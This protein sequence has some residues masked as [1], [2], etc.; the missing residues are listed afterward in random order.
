VTT[1]MIPVPS[2]FSSS[3]C[4]PHEMNSTSGSFIAL[5]CYTKTHPKGRLPVA[6]GGGFEARQSNGR[7]NVL[8]ITGKSLTWITN[9]HLQDG[10]IR[11]SSLANGE[12]RNPTLIQFQTGGCEMAKMAGIIR[13]LKK[14]EH[15]LTR[16]LKGVAAAL[17]AFGGAYGTSTGRHKISAAGRARIAAAQRSRWAKVRGTGKQK[18]K[19]SDPKKRPSTRARH[20]KNGRPA[21]TTIKGST[22]RSTE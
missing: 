12:T 11:C 13:Q 5:P 17:A 8:E 16:Q 2:L 9:L 19:S 7:I 18:K 15:Q 10:S 21:N 4:C 22:A 1:S 6:V 20:K 3:V 14:E